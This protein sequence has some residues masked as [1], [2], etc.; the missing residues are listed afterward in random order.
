MSRAF[1]CSEGIS[2]SSLVK[3]GLDFGGW[4]GMCPCTFEH[5][6]YIVILIYMQCLMTPLAREGTQARTSLCGHE[7]R[8]EIHIHRGVNHSGRKCN[9][10]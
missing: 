5:L 10:S 1:L 4:A 6:N 9:N 7:K 2:T 3:I 8:A